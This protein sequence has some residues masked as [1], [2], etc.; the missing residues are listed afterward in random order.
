MSKPLLGI[1]LGT[2]LGAFDGMT[3]WFTPA[4]RDMLAGIVMWSSV[5]GLLAGLIIGFFSRK[6]NDM[7]KGMIFG[8]IVGLGLAAMIAAMPGENGEHYWFEIMIPGSLVGLILGW[9]TQKYGAR[10]ATAR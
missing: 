6:V 3:A 4:V 7:T 9:A 5:K 1:I 2:V 8:F 10:P